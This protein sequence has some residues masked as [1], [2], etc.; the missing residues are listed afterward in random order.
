MADKDLGEE[1]EKLEGLK[2]KQF[3]I[4][5]IRM[6]PMTVGAALT[7]LGSI[8][9]LLYAGFTMYQKIEEVANL[10]VDEFNQRMEVMEAKM[11]ETTEYTRDIKNGLR[12]DIMRIEQQAD[13]TEDLVRK[14][15]DD[16]RDMIDIAE[17]RFENKRD[18]LR[19]QVVRDTKE[20]EE[21]L[22]NR[23]QQALDNPLA[24]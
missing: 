24:N 4:F 7:A 10:D 9:G 14:S 22:M 11:E 3:K 12:D 20:L 21:R 18:S 8:I 15:T 6:T 17:Q 16:V 19:Q 2:D 1:L 5:G 23:V 13:R